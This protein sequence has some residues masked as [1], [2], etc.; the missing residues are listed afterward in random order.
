MLNSYGEASG[1]AHKQ[2]LSCLC[3]EKV[4]VQNIV[5]KFPLSVSKEVLAVWTVCMFFLLDLFKGVLPKKSLYC[6]N[7]NWSRYVIYLI[8]SI[9]LET[10]KLNKQK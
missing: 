3:F 5:Q 7:T 10:R 1:Q 4:N 6:N 9:I 2:L 8:F